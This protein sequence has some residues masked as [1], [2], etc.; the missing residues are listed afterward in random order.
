MPQLILTADDCGVSEGINNATVDLYQRGYITSASVMSNFP[1]YQ[2]A[3]ELFRAHP[4]L[5][6]GA[7]LVLTDGKPVTDDIPDYC[8]IINSHRTFHNKYYVF[9][10]LLFPS[11]ETVVW[12]RH[13]LDAQLRR[14]T[15]AG[16][17]PQHITTHHHFH[18]IP[19]LRKIIYELASHYKVKWVRSHKL[20]ATILPYN[21]MPSE[22][23]MAGNLAF[24]VPNYI[25]PLKSWLNR[26]PSDYA[27][28]LM[29]FD[30]VIELV[31]HPCT[32]DDETFPN[33]MDYGVQ[34][35]YQEQLYL[36][37]MVDS[38][39]Q[40]QSQTLGTA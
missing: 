31:A 6:I 8:P 40:L 12:I 23:Q 32:E 28:K 4:N 29:E 20:R 15:E 9:S 37:D 24:D 16:I 14:F 2:H 1:A 19:A 38:L 39:R 11:D 36:I 33:T 13:E 34:P 5:E 26:S 27:S 21:M 3:V 10:R 35:R 17:Q 30:G 7:H 25:S 18:T 22:Q